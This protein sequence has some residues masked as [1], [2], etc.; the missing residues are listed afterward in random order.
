[1]NSGNFIVTYESI[2]P[3]LVSLRN[4]K[5]MLQEFWREG[6]FDELDRRYFRL[7]NV[8]RRSVMK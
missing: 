2:I 5:P 1:M 4:Y 7:I 3:N 8:L 6:L